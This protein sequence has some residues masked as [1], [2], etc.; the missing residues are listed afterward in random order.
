M[1]PKR[2]PYPG[3]VKLIKKETPR[4]IKL[5]NIALKSETIDYI[6]AIVRA[7][8][9]QTRLVL[10]VPKPFFSYEEKTI[11]VHLGFDKVVKILNN[12]K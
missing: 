7:G 2:Y 4:F 9:E 6:D 1:K 8:Y 3:K 10:R 12:Y 11:M 5:G